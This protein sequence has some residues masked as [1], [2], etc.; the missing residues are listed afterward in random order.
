MTLPF[1]VAQGRAH[2]AT[3]TISITFDTK[4]TV[5]E[6]DEGKMLWS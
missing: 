2:V 1:N 6:F 5:H 3:E 4:A